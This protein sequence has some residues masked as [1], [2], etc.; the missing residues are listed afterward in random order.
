MVNHWLPR[1]TP[2]LSSTLARFCLAMRLMKDD[3]PTLGMP[4]IITR[5]VGFFMPFAFMR[6]IFSCMTVLTAAGN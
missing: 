2:G 3:L 4:T 6:A 5:M 1:V